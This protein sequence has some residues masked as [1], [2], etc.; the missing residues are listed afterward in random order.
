VKILVGSCLARIQYA[1]DSG[2]S[3]PDAY[4]C[5]TTPSTEE[6]ASRGNKQA[7]A[8]SSCYTACLPGD[9][10]AFKPSPPLMTW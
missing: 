1:V 3:T 6:E 5:M 4:S 9:D 8:H 7:C 2:A 10:A